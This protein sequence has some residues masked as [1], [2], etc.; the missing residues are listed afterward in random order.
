MKIRIIVAALLLVLP[1]AA[2]ATEIDLSTIYAKGVS[3]NPNADL[4]VYALSWH[5]GRLFGSKLRTTLALGETYGEQYAQKDLTNA[6][7]RNQ[8]HIYYGGGAKAF[9]FLSIGKEYTLDYRHAFVSVGVGAML[10]SRTADA[11]QYGAT[12]Y[13]TIALG[14]KYKHVSI[15]IVRFTGGAPGLSDP[16]TNEVYDAPVYQGFQFKAGFSLTKREI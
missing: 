7:G 10:T 11:D 5:S 3:H 6:P 1:L 13:N 16:W 15:A 4:S 8:P 14:L 12:W 2:Q 9:K